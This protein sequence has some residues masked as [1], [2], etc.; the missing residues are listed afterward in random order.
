MNINP[1]IS[2]AIYT[3]FFIVLIYVFVVIPKKAQDKKHNELVKSLAKGEK[4]VTIGGIHGRISRIKD[5]TVILRVAEDVDIEISKRAIAYRDD[6][7]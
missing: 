4:I 7:A 6:D 3:V 2:A 5:D 1:W